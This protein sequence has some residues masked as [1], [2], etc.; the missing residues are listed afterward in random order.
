MSYNHPQLF[1][2]VHQRSINHVDDGWSTT[3]TVKHGVLLS[4]YKNYYQQSSEEA[5]QPTPKWIQMVQNG[6]QWALVVN[7]RCEKMRNLSL[8]L[9]DHDIPRLIS[10][11]TMTNDIL[12]TIDHHEHHHPVYQ[13]QA[14]P[15][16]QLRPRAGIGVGPRP[17]S[18]SVARWRSDLRIGLWCLIM[19]GYGY[20]CYIST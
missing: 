7:E 15:C 18:T 2:V 5:K 1:V 11:V 13:S 16:I 20:I 3:I 14:L 9:V 8:T 17:R 12:M 19:A 10:P 4:N 6:W